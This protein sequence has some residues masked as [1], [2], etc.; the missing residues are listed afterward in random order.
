VS[1]NW[2]EIDLALEELRLPG[3]RIQ[4]IRQPDYRSLVLGLYRPGDSFELYI[5]LASGFT[6][7]HR[8]T[9]RLG[10][11]KTPPRFVEF[12]R[13]RIRGGRIVSA[14]QLGDE[15]IVRLEI[16][17]AGEITLLWIRLWGG[18]ANIVATNTN[19]EVL[20]AFYRRPGK[21]ETAGGTFIPE[22][23]R[24]AG[25]SGNAVESDE[26][27][28]GAGS[29][30]RRP[31][32][33]FSIRELPGSGP[34]NER[35]GE[36]YFELE[37]E[38]TIRRLRS[39]AERALRKRELRIRSTLSGLRDKLGAYRDFERYREYGDLIL[40]NLH[41][42][43]KGERWVR[44]RNYYRG[45]E[46]QEIELDPEL[47]P[48]QNAERYYQRYRKAKTGLELVGEN[49]KSLERELAE[50][51]AALRSLTTEE[52][53][54][55]LSSY[56]REPQGGRTDTE[57]AAAPGLRYVS[58]G[59]EILVGRTARENDELLRRH[60]KGNDLWLHARDYPGAYVFV[61]SKP[62]KSVP[63]EVLLDAGNLALFYSKGRG[64]AQGDLYYTHV[65][66]L[67][68]AKDGKLGLVLPTQEKNLFIR[69]DGK[70]LEKLQNGEKP[71]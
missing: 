15:R 32:E 38:D 4:Q 57:R 34:F 19:G 67:R 45:D 60:V 65:K 25:G 51:G 39:Q 17:H 22:P 66:Y 16:E 46:L 26:S 48:K 14:E 56:L 64:S 68:R 53:V 31:P 42:V 37:R 30:K 35:V 20:E 10:N 70:R 58:S 23:P 62:G 5:S 24:G 18:A 50:T 63:L 43:G 11:P 52:S 13:S 1:L 6:R 33:S 54:E 29:G 59:F 47:D 7:L 8:L 28:A 41:A 71:D 61:R 36:H 44:V 12:L 49:V 21:D 3:C 2:K 69:L 9:R 55:V 27:P 40:A